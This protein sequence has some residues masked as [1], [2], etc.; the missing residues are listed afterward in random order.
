MKNR[1]DGVCVCGK[2]EADGVRCRFGASHRPL[3][4]K[5]RERE[6]LPAPRKRERLD[7]DE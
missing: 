4:R 6:R 1:W 3:I 7:D 5:P 2:E